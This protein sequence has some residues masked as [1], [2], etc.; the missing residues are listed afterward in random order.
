MGLHT[1]RYDLATEQQQGLNIFLQIT[2]QDLLV[3]KLARSS[4]GKESACNAGDPASIPGLGRSPWRRKWPHTPVFLPGE[5]HGW[6]SL[7]GYSPWGCKESDTTKRF[8]FLP[9]SLNIYFVSCNP[10]F[11]FGQAVIMTT[12]SQMRNVIASHSPWGHK[13]QIRF[14]D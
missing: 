7:V 10:H 11:T 13:T 4:V 2:K 5:S 14:S 6:R 8:H 12:I 9:L 3:R 1:V